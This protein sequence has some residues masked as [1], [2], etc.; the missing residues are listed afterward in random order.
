MYVHARSATVNAC[1][2]VSMCVDT[3]YERLPHSVNESDF[4]LGRYCEEIVM[5]IHSRSS[6]TRLLRPVITKYGYFLN[7]FTCLSCDHFL[8][9]IFCIFYYSVDNLFH[10]FFLSV[11]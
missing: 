6:S 2:S 3:V 1:I 11:L 5:I 8:L 4:G 10:V 7:M 9:E